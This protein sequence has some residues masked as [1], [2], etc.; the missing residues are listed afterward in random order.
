MIA[1]LH[2]NMGGYKSK[3]DIAEKFSYFSEK[4]QQSFYG[5]RIYRHITRTDTAFKNQML[6][7]WNRNR[8]EA[9]IQDSSK[10]NLIIFSA[11]W[12]APCVRMVPTFKEI[13]KDLRRNLIMTYVSIDGEQSAERW[14][15]KMR[16]H[17]IPW[18][19]LMVLTKEKEKA[20]R[21]DY[22]VL[23]VPLAILVHPNTMK[24]ERLNLWEEADKQRLYELV[25]R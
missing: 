15:T 9:I 17:Q 25:K 12:C 13:H 21:D 1:L 22:E 16:T 3:A 20:I 18:R 5:Q 14:R 7:V 11:S 6:P 23:G 19:S 10:F 8:S 24:M 4:L 2:M